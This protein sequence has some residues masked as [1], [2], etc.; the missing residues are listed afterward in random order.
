MVSIRCPLLERMPA[1]FSIAPETEGSTL[2]PRKLGTAI[3]NWP[4]L[5]PSVLVF[6]TDHGS[7]TD[8]CDITSKANLASATLLVIGP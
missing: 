5:Y 6:G 4:L 7:S 2:F 3:L 1:A 8:G